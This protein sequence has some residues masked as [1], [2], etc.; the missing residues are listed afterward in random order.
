MLIDFS[1]PGTAAAVTDKDNDAQV[2]VSLGR[3]P[4]TVSLRVRC[5]DYTLTPEQAKFIGDALINAAFAI[6]DEDN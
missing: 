5:F 1:I 2:V 4:G 6:P 3:A